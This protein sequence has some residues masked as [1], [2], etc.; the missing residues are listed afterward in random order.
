MG[1]LNT[2]NFR[3][4]M[5]MKKSWRIKPSRMATETINP[6]RQIVEN[7]IIE[8]N[9]NKKMIA[10]S[11]GDPTSFGNMGPSDEAVEAIVQSVRSS[12]FNGYTHCTGYKE[13]REAIANFITCPE[14]PVTSQDVIITSGCSHALDLCISVLASP[15]DNILV[16]RPGFALYKTLAHGIGV[17]TKHYDLLPEKGWEVDLDSL[18]NSIDDS[19]V[20][21]VVNNPS[22][23]CGSVFSKE[24]LKD[25]LEIA[26][27]NRIPI[28]ADEIYDDFIFP[29]KKFYRMATL[30][31]EVPILCCSGLTKKFMVPGWRTGW[32]I[33]Y[34]QMGI[35]EE[36]SI[37]KGLVSLGQR[38]I[39]AN[40]LVQ[41]AIPDILKLTP[42]SFFDDAIA[43][44]QRNAEVAF[45]MLSNINGLKPVMPSG[46]MY[47]MVGIDLKVFK[48]FADD[49]EFVERLISEQS[50]F[51]LPGKCFDIPNFV[52][53]VLTIPEEFI[54]EA[55]LRIGEFCSDHCYQKRIAEDVQINKYLDCITDNFKTSVA[56]NAAEVK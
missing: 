29:G 44:V 30:T 23:P 26:K 34:D 5:R 3:I 53:I 12:K 42:Q 47:M 55:C 21:I 54:R 36:C 16:P 24:H 2:T 14:A 50:V 17:K 33:V 38:I 1:N 27:E 40:T 43:V 37:R 45:A 39:G 4:K 25:I 13:A 18:R 52:R 11:I 9:E 6:I 41:G 10:L 48:Y 28:I 8:P 20:A 22:N 46:A 32:I 35:L 15:G 7:L 51:C 56:L 49:M 31:D 19:T